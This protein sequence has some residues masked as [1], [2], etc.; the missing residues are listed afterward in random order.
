MT[1]IEQI[2]LEVAREIPEF[3][4][5]EG[6]SYESGVVSAQAIESL[7]RC[8][9]KIGEGV[10]P[11]A[12]IIDSVQTPGYFYVKKLGKHTK[13]GTKLYAIPHEAI[14]AAEKRVAEL[15]QWKTAVEDAL[16]IDGIF[17]ASHS[18]PR[19]AVADLLAWESGVALDPA[20]SSAA[21]K[22]QDAVAEAC[23]KVCSNYGNKNPQL[24]LTVI[25]RMTADDI[26]ACLRA[27]KWRGYL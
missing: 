6:C 7:Q 16:V 20:V 4:W 15:Q 14:L 17:N 27:G 10:E 25:E 1:N 9:A 19:K 26:A 8:L 21:S 3:L 18:D 11:V 2:A 13:E 12:E 5:E 23:A 22:L 24:S